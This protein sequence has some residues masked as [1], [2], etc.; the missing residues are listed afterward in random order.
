[1]TL[2][3]LNIFVNNKYNKNLYYMTPVVRFF[4]SHHKT[5]FIRQ[6]NVVFHGLQAVSNDKLYDFKTDR[7]L[8]IL[9]LTFPFY[10]SVDSGC[11]RPGFVAPRV[12]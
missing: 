7:Q 11:T 2:W 6:H 8:F 4:S 1:M 12:P 3:R 9:Q 10:L 5:S